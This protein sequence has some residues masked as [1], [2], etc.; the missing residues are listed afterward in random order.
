MFF[1]PKMRIFASEDIPN[2]NII[3]ATSFGIVKYETVIQ[4]GLN[5][6][7]VTNINDNSRCK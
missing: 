2:V 4:S 1:N 6:N 3:N 7:I 5:P